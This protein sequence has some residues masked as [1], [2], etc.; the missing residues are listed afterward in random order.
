MSAPPAPSAPAPI[1]V[2]YQDDDVVVVNKPSGLIV[3]RGWAQDRVVVM[4]LVRNQ[5]GRD[6]YPAHRLDRGTSGALLFGL[7]PAALRTLNTEF[8]SGGVEKRYLA[9]VRGRPD[10]AEGLV[11]YAIPRTE[12]GERVPAQTLYRVVHQLEHYALV[13][14]RPLT[15]RLHQV[16]RHF[17]H[18]R[19]PI[20]LD[21]EHGRG[22][23]NARCQADCG[24]ARMA[25][26]ASEITFSHPVHAT[27]LNITAPLPDDLLAPFRRLAI[28]DAL[29]PLDK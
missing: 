24:I 29:L 2:L 10:P 17:K 4:S 23:F 16:R 25:L 1:A 28:P 7:H 3:H 5:L 14:A 9:L 22:R 18:L 8:E 15:G 11:D 21:R 27:R 12:D 26:H 19:H 20:V 6:V 13:E